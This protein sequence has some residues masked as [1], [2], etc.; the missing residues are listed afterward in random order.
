MFKEYHIANIY[1]KLT[2]NKKKT[3][4]LPNFLKNKSLRVHNMLRYN[5]LIIFSQDNN[6]IKVNLTLFDNKRKFN[7]LNIN[8]D[9]YTFK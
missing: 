5:N 9:Q 3:I 6:F 7:K 2:K 8:A 4:Y 1:N